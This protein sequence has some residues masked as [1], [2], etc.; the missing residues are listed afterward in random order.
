MHTPSRVHVYSLHTDVEP[1]RAICLVRV[2][3]SRNRRETF[4]F[5]KAAILADSIVCKEEEEEEEEEGGGV[6]ACVSVCLCVCLLL[7]LLLL[8]CVCALFD[9]R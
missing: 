8:L 1:T 4:D 2:K 3:L 7:L 5:S 9:R 6:R